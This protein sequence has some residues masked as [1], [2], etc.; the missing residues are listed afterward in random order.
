MST[1]AAKEKARIATAKS[2]AKKKEQGLVHIELWVEPS[3]AKL[4]KYQRDL[5]KETR[6]KICGVYISS[7]D[8]DNIIAVYDNGKMETAPA[9]IK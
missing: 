4:I 9:I 2:R 7:N 3:V 5:A 8:T 6:S 1:R